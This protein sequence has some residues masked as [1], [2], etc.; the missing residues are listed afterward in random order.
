MRPTETRNADE[1]PRPQFWYST[2]WGRVGSKRSAPTYQVFGKTY[3]LERTT[4]RPSLIYQFSGKTYRL[5][6]TGPRP[7]ARA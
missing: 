3:R 7:A 5:E 4:R 6:L 2:A 1:L